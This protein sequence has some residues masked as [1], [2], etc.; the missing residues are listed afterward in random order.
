MIKNIVFDIGG[1]LMSFRPYEY[2]LN[3]GY[4]KDMAEKLYKIIFKDEKWSEVD[5]G[6]LTTREYIDI[7]SN[8]SPEY[9][10]DIKS[11]LV[12]WVSMIQPIDL[13]VDFYKNLKKRGYKIYLLSNFPKDEF[14]LTESK[15]GFLK[16]ADGKVIS[17]EVKMIKPEREIYE[18]LLSKYNLVAEETLFVDDIEENVL[19]AQKIGIN[20]VHLKTTEQAIE[21]INEY[22][23][24]IK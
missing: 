1:V 13:M 22:I 10:K 8:K 17:Y 23:S 21:G 4:E 2:I 16:M 24:S 7:I 15:N 18:M 12:N 14:L 20:A 11:I 6:N 9:V 19:A 5:R 3:F